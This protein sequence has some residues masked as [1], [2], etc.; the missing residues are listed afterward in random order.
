MFILAYS[1]R[2]FCPRPAAFVTLGLRADRTSWLQG[3]VIEEV[4][5][6]SGVCGKGEQ[7]WWGKERRKKTLTWQDIP[8]RSLWP[9][10]TSFLRLDLSLLLAHS[11]EFTNELIHCTVLMTQSP[12][13]APPLHTTRVLVKPLSLHLREHFRS[14]P[15]TWPFIML[16]DFVDCYLRKGLKRTNISC[17]TM[18]GTPAGKTKGWLRFKKCGGWRD[19]FKDKVYLQLDF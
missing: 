3:L 18:S 17:S 14:S 15:P 10:M 5:H 4:T 19:N 16:I 1:F 7:R 8:Y 11:H 6:L 12:L 2:H 9:S 13:K